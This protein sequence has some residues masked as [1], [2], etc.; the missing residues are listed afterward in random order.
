MHS[1][2]VQH[3]C[4][5]SEQHPFSQAIT[6]ASNAELALIL[7]F[8][9]QQTSPV[10]IRSLALSMIEREIPS[11]ICLDASE[12]LTPAQQRWV[13][14]FARTARDKIAA[15]ERFQVVRGE[16]SD[17]VWIIY[18]ERQLGDRSQAHALLVDLDGAISGGV[19][20]GVAERLAEGLR[21][22][23]IVPLFSEDGSDTYL[24]AY[25]RPTL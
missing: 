3:C 22:V 5:P 11:R 20:G 6:Q 10:N 19:T 9:Q 13:M 7:E 2:I 15:F 12:V 8:W 14:T 17:T 1:Q 16:E 21:Q 18:H 25:F 23:E 4:Y 24:L